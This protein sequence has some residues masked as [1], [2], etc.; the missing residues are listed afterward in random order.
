M[1]LKLNFV[2]EKISLEGKNFICVPFA[3]DFPLTFN[4]DLAFD[5]VQIIEG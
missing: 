3:F 1:I 2:L 4:G 5:A